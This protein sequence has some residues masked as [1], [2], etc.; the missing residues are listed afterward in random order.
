MSSRPSTLLRLL[1]RTSSQ[2]IIS[3]PAQDLGIAETLPFPFLAMVGQREVKLA[4]LLVLI[5]PRVGGTL[6]IGPRGT[7]KTTAVRSLTDLLPKVPRSLCPYGCTEEEVEDGGM[8]A[9]C[10][11]CAQKYGYGEPLTALDRVRLIELPLNARLEDVIGGINERIAIEQQRVRLERGLL[12]LADQNILYVDEVN[13][14]DDVIINAILDAAGQGRYTVRRGPL[15]MTYR[16]RLTL[17]GSMNPEEGKLRPQIMDR[18]GLRVVV[19]GI[20][21]STQRME[22]YRRAR[23]YAENPH[24]MTAHWRD[25]TELASQE[26]QGARALLPEVELDPDAAA[27]G[28]ALIKQLEIDSHRAELT[29]F[30]A[31]RAHAAADMRQ[32]AT[33][34]DVS[35]VAVI[36]L[37]LRRSPFMRDFI[38]DRSQ[39]DGEIETAL[40]AVG[41]NGNS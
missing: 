23:A 37:R 36:A 34:D 32:T 39:E 19:R 28:L 33:M 22:I 2:A 12:S 14:L 13:M 1:E 16:A 31:A 40:H 41:F 15:R 10:P 3:Q 30:E 21:D 27:S 9:V 5:N 38:K 17:I 26:I 24:A 20:E 35:S 8:D 25:N 7:G 29:L 4:L 11:T 18:F 6:L